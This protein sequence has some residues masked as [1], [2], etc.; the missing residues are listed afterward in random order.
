LR[1]ELDIH[2]T[3]LR[4]RGLIS[5]WS[6]REILPGE[7]WGEKIDDNLEAAHIIL[8]LVSRHFLASDYCYDIEMKRA[9]ERHAAG[10]AWVIPII[11]RV[12]NWRETRLAKL[13]ALPK[14]GKPV[15]K[16]RDKDVAW[17]SVEEGIERV[18]KEIRGG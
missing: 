1:E 13:Q 8:L 4:R 10:E 17:A 18:V 6:D 5:A 2:L 9:L 15:R 12:A 16:W 7:N 11:V 3:L 14:D